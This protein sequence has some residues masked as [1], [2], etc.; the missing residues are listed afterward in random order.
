[1]AE[2]L[3]TLAERK[4]GTLTEAE[5]RLFSAIVEGRYPDFSSVQGAENDP[6]GAESWPAERT[7]AAD[8]ITWLATDRE[9]LPHVT[10][11]GI[12]LKGAR[13]VGRIDL[14]AANIE[15]ALYFERCALS[16]GINLLAAEIHAL[17]LSGCRTGRITADG[18]KVEAGVFLRAGCVVQGRVRLLGAK[19]GGN[20]DC[21]AGTFLG[22]EGEALGAD[23]I[24][25]AGSV[26]LNQ[27]FRAFGAVRLLGAKIGG[28]LDCE[29]GY[30]DNPAGDAIAADRAKIEGDVFFCDGFRARGRVGLPSV[31]C[32]S[33]FVWRD[34]AEPEQTVLDLRSAKI[35]TFWI[36]RDSWP[37]AGKLILHGLT[38]DELDDQQSLTAETWIELLRRQ[39]AQPFRPQPYEQLAAVL[40]K[41]G[42][43]AEAK[44]VLHAKEFDRARLTQ[45]TWSQWPWYRIFGPLIGFGYKPWR[46]FFVSIGVV[47][48]GTILFGLGNR[49]GLMT[50]AKAEAYEAGSPRVL[51]EHYPQLNAFMY[52]LD[53][54]TPLISLDQADYWLPNSARGTEYSLG[55]GRVTTGGLLRIYMW[56]HIIAG[57]VLSTLLFVGLSGAVSG[58]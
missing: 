41:D 2:S 7:I 44:A 28:N 38:F 22:G 4:F 56:F 58:E 52:S 17:N 30:F 24:E 48:V 14:Q 29:Q 55:V 43:V 6:A 53:T 3:L 20:L 34:V 36:T 25:V 5:R 45:L 35:G 19:I 42:H 57:W 51:S 9:A 8:R 18:M 54:F 11:R 46:A 10:H 23:G 32:S 33:F 16:A 26:L 39:P 27:G 50:P 47:I 37:A 21:Q 13:I 1:M 12:G 31:V 40:R 15:F 49:Q